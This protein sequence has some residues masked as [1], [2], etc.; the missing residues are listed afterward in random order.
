MRPFSF[1]LCKTISTKQEF[2]SYN[3]RSSLTRWIRFDL[4]LVNDFRSE[5]FNSLNVHL[6]R[7]SC[8]CE[9]GENETTTAQD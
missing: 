4:A 7:L 2:I 1:H 6:M 3:L 8:F 5:G 9:L